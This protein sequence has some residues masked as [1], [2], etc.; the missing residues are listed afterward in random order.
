MDVDDPPPTAPADSSTTN[1]AGVG[2]TTPNAPQLPIN[3]P[4]TAVPTAPSQPISNNAPGFKYKYPEAAPT[5]P[6]EDDIEWNRTYTAAD[7]RFYNKNGKSAQQSRKFRQ[8]GETYQLALQ[9]MEAKKMKSDTTTTGG[10]GSS[11]ATTK[12]AV[13][14]KPV[15][16][17]QP[18]TARM[19][20]STVAVD[21]TLVGGMTPLSI[22]EQIKS[23][24]RARKAPSAAPS[25]KQGTPAPSS[26]SKLSSPAPSVKPEKPATK[27]KGTAAPVRRPKKPKT[28]DKMKFQ[29]GQSNQPSSTNT[30]G[31]S[32]SESNDGGEYCVCRG[33]D[34]HRMMVNCEG[35]CDEWYHCSCINMDVEDAKELLDRYI[36]PTCTTEELFTS[37][38]R[39]CRYNTVGAYAGFTPCRKAARVTDQPPSKYCS[40]EHRRA[41]FEFVGDQL[42]R[43]DNAPSMGGTLNV[44]EIRDILVEA[45]TNAAI[46]ALGKKPRLPIPEGFDPNRPIGLDY[47]TPEEIEDLK[48]IDIKKKVIELRI[49]N[50]KNQQKLLVM[51]HERAQAAAKHPACEEK[52][53][54]GYD[55]R[56]AINEYEFGRWMNTA[57]GKSAFETG[58]LGPRTSETKSIS[59]AICYPGQAVPTSGEVPD[60]LNNI[61]LKAM[62][63]CIKHRGWRNIHGQDYAAMQAELTKD[64][65]KLTNQANDIIEDAETREATKEYHAHNTVEQLF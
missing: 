32:D 18:T 4:V 55:N 30:A 6:G 26:A 14:T 21:A 13:K 5:P 20:P 56:L 45:P 48:A 47:V 17:A 37:W 15:K 7:S 58:K 34:D 62:K 23:E 61:C 1:Q 19:E 22:S 29:P 44:N 65:E 43:D 3:S 42:A 9:M 50:F 54:C 2:D 49:E 57:E 51:I 60:E 52:T 36:C 35:G 59:A 16:K 31:S 39:M 27:K 12:A 25:S 63:S 38:K 24:G 64:L 40:D 53:P 46:Q 10:L 8:S 41:F 28:I 11:G 33:P